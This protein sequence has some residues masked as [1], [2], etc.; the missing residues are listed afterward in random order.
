[1]RKRT[2]CI[3]LC[4]ITLCSLLL[5]ASA[6]G[7]EYSDLPV[8]YWAYP[9]MSRA[10]SLGIINGVGDGK[11]D[12]QG[13]LTHAQCLTM[14][15]RAFAPESYRA[16][17]ASY[18]WDEAGYITALY[19]DFLL[20]DD[21]LP[22]NE[23]TLHDPI[24]RAETAVL[25]SRVLPEENIYSSSSSGAAAE[26]L[27]DFDTMDAGYAAAVSR[28]YDLGIIKG[29][30]DG[31][32]GPDDTLRRSDGTV[33]L[34]RTLSVLDSYKSE[35]N[36]VII[37]IFV[38]SL[39]GEE[40][41]TSN[42]VCKLGDSLLDIAE[43]YA[44]TGYEPDYVYDYGVVTSAGSSYR[45][46][47]LKLPDV[48]TS[49]YVGGNSDWAGTPLYELGWNRQKSLLLFGNEEQVRYS[50]REAAEANMT[51]IEVP[52]WRLKDGVKV[53][54]SA[55]LM[56]HKAMADEVVA[57]FT[58]IFNDPEQF[59]ICTLQGYD[60][61]GDSAK[62]EHNTGTAI[63]INFDQ[64]CQIKNGVVLAGSYWRPGEDP[65]S[66]PPDGSV[67]RIFAAHGWSW[68]GSAWPSSKDYM[69]FSYMGR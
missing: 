30:E 12:P 16:Y 44:P 11:M 15:G 43:K 25:L 42:Q 38:D 13:T 28:L 3:I 21:F 65:Y 55:T 7:E 34:M 64:N 40:I 47:L 61:R 1:M 51:K 69:H 27:S 39:T 31:T 68:G 46:P 62:G 29:K 23:A 8:T 52:I 59:P 33:L 4:L 22:I 19:S 66:I 32:F 2:L 35:D 41:L 26:K 10:A 58:E 50:S 5:G 18:S 67:V 20:M 54:G 9:E 60:W 63:D 24:T 53:E 49:P 6:Y 48:P 45:I 56:I 14:L 57:I 17:N 37:L 36:P